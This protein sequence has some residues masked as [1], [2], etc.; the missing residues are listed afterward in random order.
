M[1]VRLAPLAADLQRLFGSRLRSL[2][3][4]GD[5][6]GRGGSVHALALLDRVMFDDLTACAP[7]VD[8]WQRAGIAV[9]LLL[10][11]DEFARS[12]DVFPI[13]YGEIMAHHEVVAGSSPFE[14][15]R[16]AEADLRRACEMQAKSHLIHLREGYLE[17]AGR[18]EAVGAMMA[19]SLPALR[20]LVG[21]I[22][23]LEPGAAARAGMTEDLLREIEGAG[24]STI[25]DPSALFARYVS[26][27]ERLWEEVDRW[28]G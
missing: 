20:A 13:E 7:L 17:T 12:L 27:V 2:V 6:D 19:S 1:P 24:A 14:G 25:G 8:G 26:R 18:P 11:A 9:P 4:Y 22:E 28:R 21:H 23:R 3:A 10:G 16:I 15:L 5:L